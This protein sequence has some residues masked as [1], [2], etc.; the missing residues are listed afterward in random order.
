MSRV[1]CGA[2][3][4]LVSGAGFARS[5]ATTVTD[6]LGAE[7]ENLG[8]KRTLS[9]KVQRALLA[10]STAGDWDLDDVPSFSAMDESQVDG[11]AKMVR[12][13]FA[14]LLDDLVA[15]SKATA[16]SG[17]RDVITKDHWRAPV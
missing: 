14:T 5:M 15:E 12:R 10:A 16:K 2:S 13:F 17:A 4:A 3:L 9:A 11:A 7:F 6:W 8:V 1:V